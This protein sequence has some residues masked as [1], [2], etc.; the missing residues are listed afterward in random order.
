MQEDAGIPDAYATVVA[1]GPDEE[2]PERFRAI[3][4]LTWI[5]EETRRFVDRACGIAGQ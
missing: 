1:V 3:V 4:R 5:P 2:R